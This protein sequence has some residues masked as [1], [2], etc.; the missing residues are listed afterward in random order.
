MSLAAQQVDTLCHI[1]RSR[2]PGEVR[3]WLDQHPEALNG[4]LLRELAG[5]LYAA[6][7]R[8]VWVGDVGPS[9]DGAP[10]VRALLVE[11]PDESSAKAA[12]QGC[13]LQLAARLD[14]V[15]DPQRY[16]GNAFIDFSTA[17]PPAG[18]PPASGNKPA[19]PR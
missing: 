19:T 18:V 8:A 10:A 11:L 16:V 1:L 4:A 6:G 12:V 7:A 14:N 15:S 3:G 17:L 2:S 13:Y 9:G 5:A